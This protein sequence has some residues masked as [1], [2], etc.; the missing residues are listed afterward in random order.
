MT[1]CFRRWH[2]VQEMTI[3]FLFRGAFKGLTDL[4]DGSVVISMLKY[5]LAHGAEWIEVGEDWRP[6]Q[7][8]GGSDA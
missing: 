2:S 4:G 3:L 1:F 6:P 5:S 7:A 8:G